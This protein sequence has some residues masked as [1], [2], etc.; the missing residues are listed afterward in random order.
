MVPLCSTR[1]TEMRRSNPWHGPIPN[2]SCSPRS[3]PPDLGQVA[4][5]RLSLKHLGQ[6]LNAKKLWPLPCLAASTGYLK[7][8]SYGQIIRMDS[9]REDVGSCGS[10]ASMGK[11]AALRLFMCLLDP[12][13]QLRFQS[14][15][16]DQFVFWRGE[17]SSGWCEVFASFVAN[18]KSTFAVY[19]LAG[20][21][22][23]L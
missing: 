2:L 8:I 6:P 1:S 13:I 20:G 7:A 17:Q 19:S 3:K 15:N 10:K 21:R 18:L 22:S 11:K 16:S 23:L 12:D 4:L 14:N 5:N 9:G